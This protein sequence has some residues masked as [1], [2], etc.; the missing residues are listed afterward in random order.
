MAVD[1]VPVE[2][3]PLTASAGTRPPSTPTVSAPTVN[4]PTVNTPTVNT[5]TASAAR[6]ALGR[7]RAQTGPLAL[8]AVRLRLDALDQ[9]L[10][11]GVISLAVV[12]SLGSGKTT[13][14]AAIAAAGGDAVARCINIADTGG[15]DDP[16]GEQRRNAAITGAGADAVIITVDATRR[17][18]KAPIALAQQLSRSGVTVIMVITKLD[19]VLDESAVADQLRRASGREVSSFAWFACTSLD[20]T[21]NDGAPVAH[22]DDLADLAE[23]R[24]L[25]QLICYLRRDIADPHR[26]RLGRRSLVDLRRLLDS[27]EEDRQREVEALDGSKDD[28]RSDEQLEELRRSTDSA[29]TH[30][31]RWQQ[32]LNDGAADVVGDIEFE[33]RQRV[34]EHVRILDEQIDQGEPRARLAQWSRDSRQMI[35]HEIAV[36][37][38]NVQTRCAQLSTSVGEHLGLTPAQAADAAIAAAPTVPS[39]EELVIAEAS[40]S[41]QLHAGGAA[42]LV[43]RNLG[44]ASV[45]LLSLQSLINRVRED[46]AGGSGSSTSNNLQVSSGVLVALGL[47]LAFKA[48]QDE[49]KRLLNVRRNATKQSLHRF[50]DD[51]TLLLTK[52]LR[53]TLRTMQ[54][55]IRDSFATMAD[56]RIATT[57]GALNSAQRS[58]RS[59]QDRR[60]RRRQE[61]VMELD[62]IRRARTTIAALLTKGDAP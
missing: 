47:L 30:L 61:L 17:H 51:A 55:D 38:A 62:Q 27:L 42:L 37:Y 9:H 39:A 32:T 59:Q 44:G 14:V 22:H 13:L 12:G 25:V 41:S 2:A 11:R 31:A 34:R 19:R 58:T 7:L 57:M 56:E 26:H 48:V 52:A 3:G 21:A 40:L 15:L 1:L 36:A 6:E 60:K 29:R 8:P 54:R 50:I 45:L 20:R 43:A 53:D 24:G 46:T 49:R 10:A 28:E 18:D 35:E 4:T 5:P 16:D 33:F 23:P